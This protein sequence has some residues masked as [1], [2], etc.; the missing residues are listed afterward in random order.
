MAVTN[1][2]FAY[3]HTSA[4]ALG[5]IVVI[6]EAE[7]RTLPGVIDIMTWHSV[8]RQLKPIKTFSE[9]DTGGTK[10]LMMQ[11]PEIRHDGEIIAV[12]FSEAY[13]AARDASHRLIVRF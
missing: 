6:E 2:A 8:S 5:T 7:A 1:P 13:E 11:G 9:G 3:F 4:I 12:I 10:I